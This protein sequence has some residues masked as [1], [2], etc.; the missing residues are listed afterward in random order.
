MHKHPTTWLNTLL[1]KDDIIKEIRSWDNQEYKEGD[2]LEQL[3]YACCYYIALSNDNYIISSGRLVDIII[4]NVLLDS[5]CKSQLNQFLSTDHVSVVLFWE[6][7]RLEQGL[8]WVDYILWL[9][10]L[11]NLT[12]CWEYS[13]NLKLFHTF[14]WKPNF[15]L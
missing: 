15:V 6:I 12:F 14:R 10:Y 8:V 13:N 4:I 5:D 11:R 7:H 9:N 1:I 2:S 3:N